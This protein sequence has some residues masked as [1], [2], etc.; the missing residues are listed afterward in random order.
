MAKRCGADKTQERAR[1]HADAQ[2][3]RASTIHVTFQ[4]HTAR[5]APTEFLLHPYST[6][7]RPNLPPDSRARDQK[8]HY[9]TSNITPPGFAKFE[10]VHSSAQFQRFRSH[11][12]IDFSAIGRGS[13]VLGSCNGSRT[14]SPHYP[15]LTIPANSC[16][17]QR[18][19]PL[20][21]QLLNDITLPIGRRNHAGF[22]NL[23]F[24]KANNT[25]CHGQLRDRA[26]SP[27]PHL[28]REKPLGRRRQ[29]NC[30]QLATQVL[31]TI[32]RAI[33]G[34]HCQSYH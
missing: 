11:R 5:V 22:C 3:I 7:R 26:E 27:A 17:S 25:H 28:S 21:S 19:Q 16:E 10:L 20:K 29:L 23:A 33:Q 15:N 8:T 34:R 24:G 31:G 1:P 18:V 30:G 13:T 14:L 32:C 6:S 4:G 2:V 12:T 9:S